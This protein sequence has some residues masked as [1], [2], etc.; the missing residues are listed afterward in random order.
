MKNEAILSK[1]KDI[2]ALIK[3]GKWKLALQIVED[4]REELEA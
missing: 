3:K 1:L 4:L 2:E